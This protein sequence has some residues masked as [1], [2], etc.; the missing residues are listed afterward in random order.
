MGKI[1][2]TV[3]NYKVTWSF[4]NRFNYYKKILYFLH[5][6]IKENRSTKSLLNKNRQASRT[7]LVTFNRIRT[8][9]FMVITYITFPPCNKGI[10]FHYMNTFFNF[11]NFWQ[12][13]TRTL[14]PISIIFTHLSCFSPEAIRKG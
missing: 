7:T 11:I 6:N 14:C 12:I 13:T 3:S 5:C 10:E 4:H 2:I 1:S 9:H 8:I